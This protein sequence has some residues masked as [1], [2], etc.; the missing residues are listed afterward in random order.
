MIKIWYYISL[1]IFLIIIIIKMAKS[2]KL[3]NLEKFIIAKYAFKQNFYSS[4]VIT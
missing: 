3:H 2:G 1:N 4:K